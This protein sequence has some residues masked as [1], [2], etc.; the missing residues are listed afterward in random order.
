MFK[1]TKAAATIVAGSLV[2]YITL[3]YLL[4]IITSTCTTCLMY[5]R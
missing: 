1:N 4:V 2:V 5:K 3:I